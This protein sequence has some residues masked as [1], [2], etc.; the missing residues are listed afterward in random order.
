MYDVSIRYIGGRPRNAER[1]FGNIDKM[2]QVMANDYQLY[3]YLGMINALMPA[4]GFG[5][6]FLKRNI[7]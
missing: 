3:S 2:A 1:S 5:N 7:D 6:G 4:K